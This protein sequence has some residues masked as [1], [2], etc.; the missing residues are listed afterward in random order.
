MVFKIGYAPQTDIFESLSIGGLTNHLVDISRHV[1]ILTA[2]PGNLIKIA[3]IWLLILP[4]A[5]FLLG[6]SRNTPATGSG[7]GA[8]WLVLLI[9]AFGYYGVYLITPHDLDWH[10]RTSIW[11]LI[12]Q[13]WP[14]VLFL[15]FYR[16]NTAVFQSELIFPPVAHNRKSFGNTKPGVKFPGRL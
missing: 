8:A 16:M 10:L 1:Q 4:L 9:M 12:V 3:K 14:A 5:L 15:C 13:F 11:R 6:K 2:F 7:F